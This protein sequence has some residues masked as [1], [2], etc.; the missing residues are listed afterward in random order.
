MTRGWAEK[1]R[2][3]D[4]KNYARNTGSDLQQFATFKEEADFLGNGNETAKVLPSMT[5]KWFEDTAG[6]INHLFADAEKVA[7]KKKNNEFISTITDL[8]ILSGLALFHAKRIPAAVSYCIYNE[9]KDHKAFDEAIRYEKAAIDAWKSI[10]D[11][12]ADIYTD[13][14][15]MGVRN[16]DLCGHWK[17][18]LIKLE[19][20]LKQLEIERKSISESTNLN[21]PKY[22]DSKESSWYSEFNISHEKV[23]ELPVGQAL[24]IRIKVSSPAGIKW[25]K[26]NHRSLNQDVDYKTIVMRG[27]AEPGV[28]EVSVSADEIAQEWDYMYLIRVMNNENHGI[29]YPDFNKETPYVVVH[30]KR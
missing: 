6:E 22:L 8:K 23:T 30:L 2:L 15:M 4:L 9:T 7:G 3:G 12:A 16:A 24:K 14:L 17:D 18:E 1:Q 21:T 28:F 26:L 29:I 20:G 27:T 5:A 11:A 13:D 10:V 25:V 19:D